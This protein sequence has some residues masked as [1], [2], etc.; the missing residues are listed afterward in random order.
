MIDQEISRE[1]SEIFQ[2]GNVVILKYSN[3]LIL[4][5][6]GCIEANFSK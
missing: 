6:G 4:K 3:M 5:P 1:I 2:N